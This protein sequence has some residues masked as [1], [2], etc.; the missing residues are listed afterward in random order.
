MNLESI[1]RGIIEPLL[2]R[3]LQQLLI[4]ATRG[5][6]CGAAAVIRNAEGHVLLV[7]HGYGAMNW[8]IPGG[9]SQPG[10]SVMETAIREV[11]E[12]AGLTVVPE[13]LTGIYFRSDRDIHGFVFLCHLVGDAGQTHL[14]HAQEITNCRYWPIDDLPRPITD[15]TVR[16]IRDAVDGPGPV[17][18]VTL[19]G[20]PALL[21][22]ER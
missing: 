13:R 15:F 11:R 21:P 3:R 7:K 18:G 8:E 19:V 2:P 4:R 6:H 22:D 17:V 10:E 9:R 20:A 14:D 1:L 16:R 12:E 5:R